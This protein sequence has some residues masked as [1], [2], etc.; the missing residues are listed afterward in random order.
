M[1]GALWNS[2]IQPNDVKTTL[3]REAYAKPICIAVESGEVS[4]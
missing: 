2:V 1:T 3:Y 4:K